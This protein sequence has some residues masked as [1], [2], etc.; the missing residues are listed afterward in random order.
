MYWGPM[1]SVH[2][3]PPGYTYNYVVVLVPPPPILKMHI[4]GREI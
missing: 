1:Y 3:L 4:K 2:S